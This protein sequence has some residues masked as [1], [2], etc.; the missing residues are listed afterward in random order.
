MTVKYCMHT[1]INLLAIWLH[2]MWNEGAV[3]A[4]CNRTCTLEDLDEVSHRRNGQAA[5][6]NQIS[7]MYIQ[8]HP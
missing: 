2:M 8:K 4:F 7:A 5:E 1:G 3:C 6:S